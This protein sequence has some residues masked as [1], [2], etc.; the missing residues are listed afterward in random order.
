MSAL[1]WIA[2]YATWTG[3]ITVSVYLLATLVLFRNISLRRELNK[4]KQSL[5]ELKA[6]QEVI[7]TD[8]KPSISESSDE[9]RLDE[10]ARR[11][12]GLQ[13]EDGS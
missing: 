3:I 7:K 8:S 13:N 9:Q 1:S 11:I 5:E 2:G 10:I 6:K 12:S 4:T